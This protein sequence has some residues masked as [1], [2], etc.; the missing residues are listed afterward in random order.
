MI[1]VFY[2]GDYISGKHRAMASNKKG[3]NMML[4]KAVTIDKTGAIIKQKGPHGAMVNRTIFIPA[5]TSLDVYGFSYET[6]TRLV[7]CYTKLSRGLFT[8]SLHD[9]LPVDQMEQYENLA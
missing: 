9:C 6:E 4:F 5:G 7:V 8:V 1:G 2:C 3:A